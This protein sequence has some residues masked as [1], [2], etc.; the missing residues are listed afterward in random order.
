[1]KLTTITHYQFQRSRLQTPF[2]AE[3]YNQQFAVKYLLA[4]NLFC[5]WIKS[6]DIFRGD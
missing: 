1:M 3:A 5:L 4:L 2:S 6:C